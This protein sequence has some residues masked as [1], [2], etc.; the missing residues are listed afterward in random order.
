[1]DTF[2]LSAFWL[3]APELSATFDALEQAGG[4]VRAVG[5]AVRNTLMGVPISDVDLATTLLPDDIM[6]AAR[7]AGLKAVPTGLSHGTVTVVSEGR[8]FEVTTLR[9]DV[10]TD[11]RHASVSFTTDFARD[12]ARRDFTINGLY[13]DRHGNGLD[14]VGGVD[15]CEVGRV[16]FIG[17]PRQ[18]ILE[19]HLRILRFFR[20]HAGYATGA[21]DEPAL[22]A[23]LE[24]KGRI[25]TLAAERVQSEFLKIL[26]APRAASVLSIMADADIM[27]PF[28]RQAI[29]VD[30]LEAVLGAEHRIGRTGTA[31]LLL[32]ALMGFDADAFSAL[33][34]ALKLPNRMRTRGTAALAAA[35]QMPLRSIVHQR[36]MLYTYGSETFM[37]ALIIALARGFMVAELES[38][39]T[40]ARRWTR[41]R[42][43]VG[44]HDLLHN[45][46]EPGPQLGER[47]SHL[48]QLWR[49]SDFKLGREAL[50]AIDRER[51]AG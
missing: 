33:A 51:V 38:V 23:C 50:L 37:D 29:N 21:P 32:I 34:E 48:E 30:A 20:F 31:E 25:E 1:M 4:E 40:E 43:P 5:G 2:R 19:D 18:R 44:G 7:N 9:E 27:A 46:G 10:A 13:L 49:D 17:E 24:L 35:A 28:S 39:I 41:P 45:G 42:F 11:G 16:R 15:D 8:A 3:G 26:L 22:A 6:A 47:L 14:Y 36:S 12:A